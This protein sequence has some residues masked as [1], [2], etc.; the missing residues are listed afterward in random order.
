[1]KNAKKG[2]INVEAFKSNQ[3]WY[4]VHSTMAST[5]NL[6][7]FLSSKQAFKEGIEG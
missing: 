1:M 3:E 2:Y 7:R 6:E 5:V 4:C